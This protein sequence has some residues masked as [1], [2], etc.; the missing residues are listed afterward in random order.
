MR[1]LASI[2][3]ITSLNPIPNADS[4]DLAVIKGWQS[5]VPKGEYTVGETV[6][7][8]EPDA[9][10]DPEWSDAFGK[11][12]AFLAGKGV[13]TSSDG[14]RDPVIRTIRLRGVYSQGLI[15][16]YE[17]PFDPTSD[18]VGADVTEHY[19]ITKY[20]EPEPAQLGGN[21]AG[22]FNKAI[23]RTDEER[24]Q[25]LNVEQLI[26]D[27]G[28]E[29]ETFV[30]TLK[31]DGSSTS[32]YVDDDGVLHVY[33]RNLELHETE[34]NA[35]WKIAR[36]YNLASMTKGMVIQGEVY[37]EGIQRNGLKIK[38]TALA[39]FNV[40]VVNESFTWF[41][42]QD[43][44]RAW[45]LIHDIPF[46]N[47]VWRGL[48]TEINPEMLSVLADSTGHEGVVVR[49]IVNVWSQ[50]LRKNLSFKMVSKKYLDK[51]F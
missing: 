3:T 48:G 1:T 33:S 44:A 41:M 11:P 14:R 20:E 8:I 43:E 19:G 5:V 37:G 26:T 32:A 30:A 45:C 47:E 24:I 27:L 50:L 21:I 7:F 46:V 28:L 17:F 4:L 25:N 35:F 23:P 40:G 31:Y 49:P 42:E 6:V 34:G 29:N 9:M 13:K 15:I 39:V 16:K 36:K 38:G 18:S 2:Q 22:N 51:T 10:V 12:F